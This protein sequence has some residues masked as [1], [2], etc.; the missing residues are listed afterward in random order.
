[1]GA[2]SGK[3]LGEVL[4]RRIR[5]RHDPAL[6]KLI[7]TAARADAPAAQ[8]LFSA[9]DDRRIVL[10]DVRAGAGGSGRAS[11]AVAELFGHTSWV[12]SVKASP[13]GRLLLSG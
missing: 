2:A 12:L 13:D 3:G 6:L 4:G 5:A 1:M 9:S 11:A 8:W 7:G 10:H